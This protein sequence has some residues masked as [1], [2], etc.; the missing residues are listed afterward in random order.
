MLMSVF[1][2]LILGGLETKRLNSF[3]RQNRAERSGAVYWRAAEAHC[4][5]AIH[6]CVL[7]P[8]YD[9]ARRYE[10][11]KKVIPE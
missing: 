1:Y 7:D 10:V 5:P 11:G 6:E 2:Q 4:D 8:Q 9:Y 3:A